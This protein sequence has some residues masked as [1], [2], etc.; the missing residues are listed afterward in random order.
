[1]HSRAPQNRPSGS[2]FG[3]RISVLLLAMFATMATVYVAGRLW[4][5]AE[6]R[7]YLIQELDK[8]TGQDQSAIS[9]D[10]TLKLIACREQQKKLSDLEMDLAA[11]TQEGFVPKHSSKNDGTHAKK[12]TLAVIGIITTFGRK[13]NRDAIRKAWMPTGA[14]LEKL[15]D[16]KGIIVRF[17]IGRSTNRGDSLDREID[18]ENRQTKDFIILDG[19]VE[20]TEEHPKKMKSFFTHAVENWDAEFYAKANDDVYV[21]IDALGAMLTTHLDKPRLYMGCMKSGEVFSEPTHKWY[22]PD[23]WKFGDKKSYFRHASGE[24]YVISKALARF[25]SINRSILRTY[26][27]DDVSSGSWFIGLD[28]NHIDE[29]KFCCSWSSG[30]ICA[31]V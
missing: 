8:R 3:S 15:A 24:L 26:A 2:S 13:K 10:D 9:V 4:Q 14:A 6:N 25:I 29:P 20:A 19:Q 22:E 30:A 28:V 7:V 23:W 18:N 16:E 21:N 1:M 31:A 27:H 11:A 12:K 5:D 17:V